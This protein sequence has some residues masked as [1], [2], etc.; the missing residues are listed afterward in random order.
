MASL[1][2]YFF[3]ER[4]FRTKKFSY[5]LTFSKLCPFGF[6][7]ILGGFA[8]VKNTQEFLILQFTDFQPTTVDGQTVKST[9][10]PLWQNFWGKVITTLTT[11]K[12]LQYTS[13]DDLATKRMKDL[14]SEKTFMIV[15]ENRDTIPTQ[16]RNYVWDINELM[17]G[18][19]TGA[20]LSGSNI[21]YLLLVRFKILSKVAML[22]V[23]SLF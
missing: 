18:T 6:I 2:S 5:C 21:Y 17:S 1:T 3:V 12:I 15:S 9:T 13:V 22:F 16:Y 23:K 19:E 4:D 20:T 7:E 8:G 10:N 11:D 14:Q